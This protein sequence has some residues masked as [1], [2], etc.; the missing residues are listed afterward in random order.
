MAAF[1]SPITRNRK[2]QCRFLVIHELTN[3]D[4]TVLSANWPLALNKRDMDAL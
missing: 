1:F 2:R 4:A 3:R